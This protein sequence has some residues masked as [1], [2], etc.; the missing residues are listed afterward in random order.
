MLQFGGSL[1]LLRLFRKNRKSHSAISGS[2]YSCISPELIAA[3][4]DLLRYSSRAIP[5]IGCSNKC[6]TPVRVTLRFSVMPID[7]L[8]R[9]SPLRAALL[10]TSP[11]MTGMPGCISITPT[12]IPYIKP[13]RGEWR[14]SHHRGFFRF[15]SSSRNSQ[16]FEIHFHHIILSMF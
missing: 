11:D 7:I 12:Y 2:R 8:K 3:C 14:K 15:H 6:F 9:P 16:P 5:Q 1:S 13:S 10:V 4:H